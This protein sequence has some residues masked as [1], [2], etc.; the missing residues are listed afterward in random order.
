MQLF[1]LFLVHAY[2]GQVMNKHSKPK[3]KLIMDGPWRW[4]W[5]CLIPWIILQ[6]PTSIG[7]LHPITQG[8]YMLPKLHSQ[9]I[10][11]FLCPSVACQF[12]VLTMVL[13]IHT[14]R[15]RLIAAASELAFCFSL[16]M[17]QTYCLY[18]KSQTVHLQGLLTAQSLH[19]REGW[20]SAT[21]HQMSCHVCAST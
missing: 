15:G 11:L 10:C 19:F 21:A 8:Q 4:L 20:Y 9:T 6:V 13:C 1:L 14:A 5:P 17:L 12:A 7:W 16:Q 18:A 3:P 2:S